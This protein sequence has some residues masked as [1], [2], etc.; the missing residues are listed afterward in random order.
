MVNL[1]NQMSIVDDATAYAVT[2]LE[3]PAER[4]VEFVAG[5]DDSLTVWLN[6]RRSSRT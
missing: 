4:A 6:A 1:R 2:E 5:S 3:A